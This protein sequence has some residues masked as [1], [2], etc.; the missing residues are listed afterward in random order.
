MGASLQSSPG[1]AGHASAALTSSAEVL[2]LPS[3]PAPPGSLARS[4][5]GPQTLESEN[6]SPMA[7]NPS[8]SPLL[9]VGTSTSEVSGHAQ[10]RG[11]HRE[12]APSPCKS[13]KA[14]FKFFFFLIE[15]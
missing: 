4:S 13:Q 9:P 5:L 15:M 11:W 14:Q 7:R 6:V 3:P 12:T 1:Q 2:L 10:T 8:M